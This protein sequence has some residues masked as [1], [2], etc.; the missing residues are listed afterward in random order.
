MLRRDDVLGEHAS[1]RLEKRD[2]LGGQGWRSRQNGVD[3][4]VDADHV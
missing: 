3:S 4:L 1:E 2:L